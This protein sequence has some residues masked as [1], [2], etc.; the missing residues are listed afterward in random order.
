MTDHSRRRLLSL[1]PAAV[2]VA[3]LLAVAAPLPASAW[4]LEPATASVRRYLDALTRLDFDAMLD[5][6]AEDVVV[7]LPPAPEGLPRRIEGKANLAAFLPL[8]GTLWTEIEFSTPDVRG[9]RDRDRVVAEY[10][11]VGTFTNG[12]PYHQT[13]ANLFRVHDCKIV[14]T[15]EFFDPIAVLAGMAPA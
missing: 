3:G 6:V 1:L 14:E 4:I 9:E 10:T 13:Y 12:Q 5:E 8:L 11:A 15:K 2:P 7:L